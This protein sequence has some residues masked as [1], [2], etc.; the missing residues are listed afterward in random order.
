MTPR[1]G[2][3]EP[4]ERV[5]PPTEPFE[6]EFGSAECL[7]CGESVEEMHAEDAGYWM[8]MHSF[9][10]HPDD[11]WPMFQSE[12]WHVTFRYDFEIDELVEIDSTR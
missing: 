7:S 9:D 10:E 5:E 2:Y 1:Y 6:I 4:P 12:F 3:D 8:H 11:E